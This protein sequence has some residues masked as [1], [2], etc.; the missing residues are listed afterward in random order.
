MKRKITQAVP[1]RV[2]PKKRVHFGTNSDSSDSMSYVIVNSSEEEEEWEEGEEDFGEASSSQPLAVTRTGRQ[3]KRKVTFE[4]EFYPEGVKT[5]TKKSTYTCKVPLYENSDFIKNHSEH[6]FRCDGTGY[7]NGCVEMSIGNLAKRVRLLLCKTCSYSI[8]NNCLPNGKITQHF[9]SDGEYQC[10]KCSSRKSVCQYDQIAL[11]KK[12]DGQIP[13]RCNACYRGFHQKCIAKSVSSELVDKFKEVEMDDLYAKG[14]C[15][16][17]STFGVRSGNAI[18]ER[19]VD[20]R[21]ELLIKWKNASHRHTN[22]VSENWYKHVH[23]TA[24]KAYLRKKLEPSFEALTTIPIEWKTVDRI[25]NVE[26]ENKA[27]LKAKRILAVYKDISYEDG[28]CNPGLCICN[29][30]LTDA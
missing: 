22:W 6:C 11:T 25:L 12:T 17:C 8:H 15:M 14:L 3:T 24:Y 23:S 30:S 4:N 1:V 20:D 7:Y 28:K 21:K 26:W 13:F 5:K 19:M 18:G 2:K 27:E 10:V 16:E 9:N 29:I